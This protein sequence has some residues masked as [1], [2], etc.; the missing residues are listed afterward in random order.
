VTIENGACTLHAGY[1]RLQ[2]HIQDINIY[3]FP[4]ATVVTQMHISGMFIR[5]SH[6]ACLVIRICF[7]LLAVSDC[8]VEDEG[9]GKET[10]GKT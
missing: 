4:T 8:G 1:I 10:V 5:T 7:I 6:I 9:S 2:A 3:N